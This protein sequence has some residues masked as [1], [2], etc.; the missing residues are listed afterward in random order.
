VC[1]C[2]C[3]RVCACVHVCACVYVHMCVSVHVHLYSLSLFLFLSRTH[4]IAQ[5]LGNMLYKSS[6]MCDMT[7]TPFESCHMCDITHTPTLAFVFGRV[8]Y[9]V[10]VCAFMCVCLPCEGTAP[11]RLSEDCNTLRHAA[12][13]CNTLHHTATHRNT[14]QQHC[15]TLQHT[16]TAPW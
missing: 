8:Y 2:V 14:P 5:R 9:C 13:H 12:T 16:T 6:H 7:H 15:N 4:A 10:L 1:V 3:V 11:W